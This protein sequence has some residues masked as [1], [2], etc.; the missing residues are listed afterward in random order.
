MDGKQIVRFA[1]GLGAIGVVLWLSAGTLD[2]WQGWAYFVL[3]VVTNVALTV[4]LARTDPEL[5]KRRMQ[6]RESSALQHV[7]HAL[8]MLLWLG[9]LVLA[10]MEHRR[11][12][13]HG[14]PAW[15]TVAA[16]AGLIAAQGIFYAVFRANRF[17]AATIRVEAGQTVVSTGPYAVVRHPM[18]SGLALGAML[19]P[20]ALGSWMALWVG[21]A[22]VL[23]VALR[24][25]DEE[26][27]LRRDL[28]GYA[29]YCGQVRWRLVPGVF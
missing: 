4:Y 6:R 28:A 13:A 27:V 24:L 5:L 20:L 15:L 29:E 16:L 8:M 11:E 21:A 2:Y 1:L 17:A 23:V 9:T 18:Y 7:L 10:G 14:V 26:R 22:S 25:L 12:E 3:T 19:T